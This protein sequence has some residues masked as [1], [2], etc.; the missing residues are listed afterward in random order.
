S[1]ARARLVFAVGAGRTPKCAR[2]VVR[3][4]K[5]RRGRVNPTGKARRDLLEQPT[6]AVRVAERG[7]RAVAAACGIWTRDPTPPEQER[8]IC[9]RMNLATPVKDFAHLHAATAEI[10]ASG[11]DVRHDQVQALRRAR[12]G[13]GDGRSEDDRTAGARRRELDDAPAVR[14]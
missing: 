7:V 14:S 10:L 5:G 9:A 1:L 4:G 2:Q 12:G 11:L 8:F 13:G 6:V 3:R